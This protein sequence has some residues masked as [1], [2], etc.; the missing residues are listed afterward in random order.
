MLS[1]CEPCCQ[2]F[3]IVVCA[4]YQCV[5]VGKKKELYTTFCI[6]MFTLY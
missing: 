5:C 2:Y 1:S 6:H 4:M 3:S